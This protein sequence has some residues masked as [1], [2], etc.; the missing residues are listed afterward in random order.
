MTVDTLHGRTPEIVVE[1]AAPR[2]LADHIPVP[3]HRR[4]VVVHE[5]AIERV[6]ITTDRDERDRRVDAPPGWLARLGVV[7]TYASVPLGRLTEAGSAVVPSP[8]VANSSTHHAPRQILTFVRE[9]ATR[10]LSSK[11]R[12]LGITFF[13]FSLFLPF[14]RRYLLRD[15]RLRPL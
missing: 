7:T 9:S 3:H 1:H 14:G 11:S 8:H 2:R 12:S 10:T 6:E 5:V 15:C 13:P 4:Y